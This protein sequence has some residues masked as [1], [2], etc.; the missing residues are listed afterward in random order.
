MSLNRRLWT[1][2]LGPDLAQNS[3]ENGDSDLKSITSGRSMFPS[4]KGIPKSKYFARFGLV[5]LVNSIKGMIARKYTVPQERAKPFRI[6]LSLMDRWEV[7]GLIVPEIFLPVLRNVQEYYRVA[8][9]KAFDEVLRSA[10]AFFDGV[11]SSLIFSEL[12]TLVLDMNQDVSDKVLGNLRLARFA[13]SHFNIKEEEMLTI[14]I[15]LLLL[16][17]LLTM[18]TLSSTKENS[19]ISK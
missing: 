3:D 15:P 7:G 8:T 12:L 4:E 19:E 1:W 9:P 6:S 17:T 14:H 13:I 10:S 5:P 16:G 18:K 2:F 11:E